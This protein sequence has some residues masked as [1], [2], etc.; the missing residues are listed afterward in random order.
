MTPSSP[1]SRRSTALP[2]AR[3]LQA[4]YVK[5]PSRILEHGGLLRA[6]A[7]EEKQEKTAL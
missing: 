2:N 4:Y 1:L 6:V 7:A 5:K 3:A